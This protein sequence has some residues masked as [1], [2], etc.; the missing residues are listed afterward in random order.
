MYIFASS[1]VK[2]DARVSLHKRIKRKYSASMERQLPKIL[3]QSQLRPGL[4]FL[5]RGARLLHRLRLGTRARTLR[6]S[7]RMRRPSFQDVQTTERLIETR[8]PSFQIY[9]PKNRGRQPIPLDSGH[10]PHLNRLHFLRRTL[11]LPP[12]VPVWW[13]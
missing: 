1:S 9:R 10:P 13:W 7:T 12:V 4:L 2:G 3:L 6:D 8:I 11:C 5:R